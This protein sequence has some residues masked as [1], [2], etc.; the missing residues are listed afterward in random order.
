MTPMLRSF[1]FVSFAAF[2][3]AASTI[4]VNAQA[5]LRLLTAN[6]HHFE[7]NGK[8]LLLIGSGEH[9]GAVI[10]SAFD[11]NT[12]L[13][14]L[15]KDGLNLTRLFPGAYV[16]RPGDFGI[17]SNLLAPDSNALLLPWQRSKIP[18]YL[19]GGNKFDLNAWDSKYFERLKS[20][21]A[22][23]E[24]L[25][26]I[27]EV[28][29]FSSH[30]ATGWEYCPFNAPNNVNGLPPLDAKKANT[31]DNG[32]LLAH[33]EAY[34]RKLVQELHGFPN[35]YFEIQNEPWADQTGRLLLR[36]EYNDPKDW[37]SYLQVVSEASLAWQSKV[38]GW[39]TSEEKKLGTKH[40]IS[41][42]VSNFYYP[43]VQPD[44]AISIFNFHYAFPRAVKEN[45][46]LQRPIGFNETGFSGKADSIYLQQAWRFL[47]AGG[48]LFNHLDYSFALQ[49]PDGRDTSYKAPGG[50]SPALRSQLGFMRK[51]LESVPISSMS[52][53]ASCFA[54]AGGYAVWPLS[55]RKKHWLVY[56]ERIASTIPNLNLNLPAGRYRYQWYDVTKGVM[57]SDGIMEKQTLQ[58]PISA[59]RMC[60]VLQRQP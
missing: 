19:L 47:C 9:Y 20:Y 40:L 25:G 31:L 44:P 15:A 5:P 60:L 4:R 16:E 33:Q 18:G 56:V 29:L 58:V 43:V 57:L 59:Y 39:I 26:I 53:D 50:G 46:H 13:K 34:V 42:N 21:V 41:Q 24:Q 51:T 49:S 54:G 37:R 38:A 7:Y 10:N 6:P 36:D 12:Y 48:A 27:V 1:Y 11:Y 30:Y 35:I 3:V 17:A 2:L 8:P 22:Q 55:D 14:T 32:P 45:L 28:C 23:A 52:P